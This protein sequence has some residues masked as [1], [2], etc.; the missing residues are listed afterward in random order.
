MARRKNKN[1]RNI[2]K[3]QDTYYITIPIDFMRKLGWRERQKVVIKK[4]WW[5]LSVK[6][7]S[8]K[9]E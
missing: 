9:T 6:D 2:Q 8:R 7:W 1:I 3:S 4:R 5:G